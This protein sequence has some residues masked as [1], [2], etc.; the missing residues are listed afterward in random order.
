MYQLI[1]SRLSETRRL[2]HIRLT[3]T[4]EPNGLPDAEFISSSILPASDRDEIV[5][6]AGLRERER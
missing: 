1:M 4:V 3:V 2:L 5:R 6:G